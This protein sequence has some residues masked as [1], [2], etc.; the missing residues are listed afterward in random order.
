MDKL[1]L[2]IWALLFICAISARAVDIRFSIIEAAKADIGLQ[3]YGGENRGP[4]AKFWKFCGFAMPQPYCACA[5]KYWY[6]AANIVLDKMSALASSIKSYPQTRRPLPGDVYYKKTNYG[7]GHVGIVYNWSRHNDYFK[8]IDGNWGDKIVMVRSRKR[9]AHAFYSPLMAIRSVTDRD[10]K[11]EHNLPKED[12]TEPVKIDLDYKDANAKDTEQKEPHKSI[13][14]PTLQ[15]LAAVA[16]LIAIVINL[17][18][19]FSK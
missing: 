7:S 15:L 6:N 11:P 1:R 2:H 14:T 18:N 10:L 12:S 9:M 3:E 19:L 5:V 4:V 13:A 17:L 8:H 16:L